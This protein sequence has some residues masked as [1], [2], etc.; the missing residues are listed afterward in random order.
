MTSSSPGQGS[1][2]SRWKACCAAY[3]AFFDRHPVTHAV[4]TFGLL[5]TFW[6]LFQLFA[7]PW[8]SLARCVVLSAFYAAVV[9]VIAAVVRHRSARKGRAG[10]HR[11]AQPVT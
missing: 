9:T 4:Y 6:T 8:H 2:T 3:D 1:S 11:D 7:S 10:S 5:F